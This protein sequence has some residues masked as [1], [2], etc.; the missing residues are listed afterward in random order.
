MFSIYV[1]FLLP[2]FIKPGY[3][4]V[5]PRF[6]W[7]CWGGG[8]WGLAPHVILMS[9]SGIVSN[10]RLRQCGHCDSD[11]GGGG[12]WELCLLSWAQLSSDGLVTNKINQHHCYVCSVQ[13][14]RDLS[15]W[16]VPV[17]YAQHRRR[18][19]GIS[20]T[21]FRTLAFVQCSWNFLIVFTFYFEVN[22]W[23][24]LADKALL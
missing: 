13:C 6:I 1:L 23:R 9:V 24:C 17:Q 14:N 2:S 16:T 11:T 20:I 12:H 18:L 7:C 15:C 4:A 22:I 21:L 3:N 8:G 19:N 5:K 10:E